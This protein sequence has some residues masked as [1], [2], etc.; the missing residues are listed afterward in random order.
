[1]EDEDRTLS[2][3]RKYNLS[4]IKQSAADIRA[5][6]TDS[7]PPSHTAF[8][9][10]IGDEIKNMVGKIEACSDHLTEVKTTLAGLSRLEALGS[11]VQNLMEA[12]KNDESFSDTLDRYSK[13]RIINLPSPINLEK[14]QKVNPWLS[15]VGVWRILESI[16]DQFRRIIL[17]LIG[18]LLN[19]IKTIPMFIEIKPT[20]SVG[21]SGFLPSFSLE[22]DCSVQGASLHELIEVLIGSSED[23]R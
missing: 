11:L 9:H 20:P 18:L 7:A 4:M 15:S 2:I 22:V 21:W 19:A 17:R 16:K 8:C 23:Q 13:L 12:V 5:I 1:M 6:A 3:V 10:L 14:D